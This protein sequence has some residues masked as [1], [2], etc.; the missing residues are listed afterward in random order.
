MGSSRNRN[1]TRR[2]SKTRS[3]EPTP[4]PR[5]RPTRSPATIKKRLEAR[6]LMND[7]GTAAVDT[8]RQERDAGD[9]P[10]LS[11]IGAELRDVVT[12]LKRMEAYLI[13]AGIA[14]EQG[15]DYSGY[16]AIL[17][18]RAVGNLL[19]KQI[20]ALEDLAAQCDGGPSSDRD[21]EDDP[22]EDEDSDID[23]E[24]QQ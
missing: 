3:F 24:G 23:A 22:A 16:I 14:V 17:L 19:F 2:G 20:R 18:K 9:G 15:A 6:P 4:K 8:L 13:V 10:S 21:H 11:D 5:Q 7:V 1:S 12:R